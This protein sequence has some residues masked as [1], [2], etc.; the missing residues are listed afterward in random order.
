MLV[1]LTL[2]DTSKPKL[3][4]N[5][6]LSSCLESVCYGKAQ[7]NFLRSFFLCYEQTEIASSLPLLSQKNITQ[8]FSSWVIWVQSQWRC[9]L[10]TEAE[11]TEWTQRC[12]E[13]IQFGDNVKWAIEWSEKSKMPTP[14]LK[15]QMINNFTPFR[16]LP[17]FLLWF[18]IKMLLFCIIFLSTML[19]HDHISLKI[20]TISFL[21]ILF[22]DP[23]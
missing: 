13:S 15:M 4:R 5:S 12:Q 19:Y 23:F 6:L 7:N 11:M 21:F 14:K 1:L 10:W 3:N 9:S 2:V 16:Q 8:M 17:S 22:N 20:A 18:L